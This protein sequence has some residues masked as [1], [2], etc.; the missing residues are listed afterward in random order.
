[1]RTEQLCELAG[2]ALLIAGLVMLPLAATLMVVGVVLIL[3]AQA[4][5]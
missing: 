3:V 1:M 2:L 4:M 5:R